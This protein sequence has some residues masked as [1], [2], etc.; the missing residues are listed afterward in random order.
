MAQALLQ[1]GHD[2]AALFGTFGYS[3]ADIA[4]AMGVTARW[5]RVLVARAGLRPPKK[6]VPTKVQLYRILLREVAR[7]GGEYGWGFLSGVLRAWHPQFHFERRKVVAALHRLFPKETKTRRHYTAQRLERGRCG[8]GP[9]A[10]P[11]FH[12]RYAR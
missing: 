5:V 8:P 1:Q 12:S 9:S 6:P 11:L 4:A 2:A 10:A 7:H 3:T